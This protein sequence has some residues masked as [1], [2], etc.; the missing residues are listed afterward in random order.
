MPRRVALLLAALGL[1]ACHGS[2]ASPSSPS[3]AAP[4]NLE[5]IFTLTIPD[6]NGDFELAP[7]EGP[8]SVVQYAAADV[9]SVRLGM[10]GQYLYIQVNYAAAV[11][12]AAATIPAQSGM[13]TQFVRRQSISF[14]FNV[15][16]NDHNGASAFP[17]ITGIDIFFG[18]AITYGNGT[19]DVYAHWDF[20]NGDIHQNRSQMN[21]EVVQSA[22]ANTITARFDV[23]SLGSFFPRGANVVVGGWSEAESSDAS[24]NTIYHHFA[25]DPYMAANW[26]IPR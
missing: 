10:S 14:N 17:I 24:G 1:S 15:D 12:T 5:S 3:I 19:P 22:G 21:G 6:A 26:T 20:A 7:A 13:S 11:P 23:S 25:Y 8:P 9:S 4:A 18:F 16:G 2:G